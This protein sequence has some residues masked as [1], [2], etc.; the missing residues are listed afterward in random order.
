MSLAHNIEAYLERKPDF[1]NEVK[2]QDDGDGA[3]IKE[4]NASEA[5]PTKAELDALSG[6]TKAIE[7]LSVVHN[8]RSSE[9]PSI[10]E[11]LDMIYHDSVDGTTIWKDAVASVK[12]KYP[13]LK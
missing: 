2:L 10:R 5:Q 7:D 1:I 4:W 6:E 8:N 11:Q 12:D 13:K 3:Y 9:Y